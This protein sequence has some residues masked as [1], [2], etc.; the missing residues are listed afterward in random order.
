MATDSPAAKKF[1]CRRPVHVTRH[2]P[3]LIQVY[4]ATTG[5][6]VTAMKTEKKSVTISCTIIVVHIGF[7]VEKIAEATLSLTLRVPHTRSLFKLH[8]PM[9]FSLPKYCTDKED[10]AAA[11]FMAPNSCPRTHVLYCPVKRSV[12]RNRHGDHCIMKFQRML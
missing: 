2:I 4:R 8:A 6:Q 9:I 5:P 10:G 12:S 1:Q 3:G 11:N 7:P